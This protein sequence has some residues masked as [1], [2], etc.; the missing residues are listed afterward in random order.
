MVFDVNEV[1]LQ[2]G[3]EGKLVIQDLGINT[4]ALI[5]IKEKYNGNGTRHGTIYELTRNIK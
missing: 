3:E 1:K 5:Y 2:N 4:T